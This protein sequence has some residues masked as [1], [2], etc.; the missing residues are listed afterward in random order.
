[1]SEIFAVQAGLLSSILVHGKYWQEDNITGE[2]T[3]RT[4]RFGRRSLSDA[5]RGEIALQVGM[6]SGYL[7]GPGYLVAGVR[8][9]HGVNNIAGGLFKSWHNYGVYMDLSYWYD[10]VRTRE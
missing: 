4:V 3:R 8:F 2:V 7:V 1:M 9:W 5:R 6:A 10:P